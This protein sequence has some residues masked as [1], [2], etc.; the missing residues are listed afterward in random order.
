MGNVISGTSDNT[1]KTDCRTEGC[2][3]N[4][5]CIREQ[6]FFV[7]RCLPGYSGVPEIGCIR[8]ECNELRKN[9]IYIC[10]TLYTVHRL[11]AQ[12]EHYAFDIIYRR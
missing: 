10:I 1:T 9:K 5:E 11:F 6:A 8:G 4:S 12:L 7:C 2:G 3:K